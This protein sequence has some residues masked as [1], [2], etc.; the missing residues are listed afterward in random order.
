MTDTASAGTDFAMVPTE[1]SDAGRYIQQ[2]AQSLIDG[3]R[4]ADTE[5]AGLMATWRGPAA[6]AY[7]AAWGETRQG[8]IRILEALD[9]M[10]ELL[11]VSVANV[12][13]VETARVEATTAATS[14]LDLP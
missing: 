14:S 2:A 10:G 4:S 1:V 5:V 3:I 11:G 8:A 13:E 6:D 9:G 7:S 12:A